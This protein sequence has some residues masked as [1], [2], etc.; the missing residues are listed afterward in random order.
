MLT[1]TLIVVGNLTHDPE[2]RFTSSGLA[3]CAFTIASNQKR[4]DKET[5][6]WVDGSVAFVDC[7]AWRI[8]A[9]NIVESLVKGTSVIAA[10]TLK[11]ESWEDNDGNK[12]SRTKLVV[13]AVGPNLN[14]HTATVNR[15]H[16]AQPGQDVPP[17]DLWAT[18][19]R[20][21]STQDTNGR[22]TAAASLPEGST[23]DTA[24]ARTRQ[25]RT[26]GRTARATVPASDEPPF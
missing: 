24:R 14:W 26:G 4:Y 25:T 9:E 6:Q 5:Q 16:R 1:N 3:V 7:E 17:D 15:M 23:A 19:T 8:M 18:G 11:T 20:Q 12:R 21:P 22:E 2:L 13:D 10:G